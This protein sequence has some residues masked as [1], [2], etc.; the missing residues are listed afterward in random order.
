MRYYVFAFLIGFTLSLFMPGC[1]TSRLPQWV[2]QH[3]VHPDYYTGVGIARKLPGQT[4]HV[5]RARDEALNEI[6]SNIAVNIMSESILKTVQEAGVLKE[7]FEATITSNTKALLEG[8]ELV[9][10]WENDKEFRA[11]YRLSKSLHQENMRRRFI[12]IAER[13]GRYFDE[14][15]RAE[16]N[17]NFAIALS[18]YLQA[19]CE[20]ASS[21]GMELQR[22]GGLP[23]EFID[24]EIFFR[25]RK[26]LSQVDIQV[27]PVKITVEFFETPEQPIKLTAV[28]KK[29]S[30]EFIALPGLPILHEIFGGNAE[31]APIRLTDSNGETELAIAR[32]LSSG[33]IQVSLFPDLKGLCSCNEEC[34][35]QP[36]FQVLPLPKSVLTIQV[37]PV[38]IAFETD[39]VNMGVRQTFPVSNAM[40]G[41]AM[42]SKGWKVVN[43]GKSSDFIIKMNITAK[44]GTERM[45]V[46]TAFADGTLALIQSKTGEEIFI[47]T[48]SQVPGGGRN[49]ES[50]GRQAIE[51]LTML[52][53]EEM[54]NRFMQ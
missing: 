12:Q 14:G 7:T 10:T 5:A 22:P 21:W 31:F 17:G 9:E 6:A 25:L 45:G 43:T 46:H 53:I 41:E 36:I 24:T 50:A 44:P 8:Y 37:P 23:A 35:S 1:K 38:L 32:A 26:L 52:F 19:A 54:N 27:D 20:V 3:P 4:D 40:V 42:T 49:Y 28:Y 13:A 48:N 34:F 2:K 15:K 51:K 29:N 47:I 39:E 33:S 18:N 16:V 30:G 11:Y